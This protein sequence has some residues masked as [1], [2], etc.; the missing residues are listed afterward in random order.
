[1]DLCDAT[2]KIPQQGRKNK[3]AVECAVEK[4][5]RTEKPQIADATRTHK[6]AKLQESSLHNQE[7]MMIYANA[8]VTFLYDEY[9]YRAVIG[10]EKKC[11]TKAN[12]CEVSKTFR[13]H[14]TVAL[15]QPG[16][17]LQ[18]Q[19]HCAGQAVAQHFQV[20]CRVSILLGCRACEMTCDMLT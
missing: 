10:K 17:Q 8:A 1:M 6:D 9:N 18:G 15:Q 11:S 20:G 5:S 19:E 3:V 4:D 16:V 7:I 2:A 14:S 12:R 13:L